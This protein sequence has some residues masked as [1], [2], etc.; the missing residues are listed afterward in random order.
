MKK[1]SILILTISVVVAVILLVATALG[2]WYFTPRVFLRGVDPAEID[3]I[4]VFN[5]NTGR[6]FYIV[7]NSD[8]SA[9][10]ENIQ[11]ISMARGKVSSNYNGFAFS[12]SFLDANGKVIDS[13]IVN[14]L[15][16]ICDDPFFYHT[17]EGVLC[18]EHLAA[19]EEEYFKIYID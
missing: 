14:G 6:H 3:R 15:N 19:L 2:A 13:F 9:V 8:I 1:K 17:S 11:G 18:Y 10:V 4:E 16:T 12:L 5:G 7:R